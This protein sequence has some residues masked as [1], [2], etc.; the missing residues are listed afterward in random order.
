MVTIARCSDLNQALSFK[1][2]LEAAGIT[3][4]IPDEISASTTPYVFFGSAGGVR[5]QVADEDAE[6]AER[7]IQE[8]R[9]DS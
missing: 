7:I 4:F 6:K 1:M 2:A 9:E 8:L 3:A 5:V